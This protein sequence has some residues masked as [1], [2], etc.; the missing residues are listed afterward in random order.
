MAN[1][2]YNQGWEWV[3]APAS[4]DFW[5]LTRPGSLPLVG[6]MQDI[7]DGWPPDMTPLEKNGWVFCSHVEQ[8]QPVGP[9]FFDM[10]CGDNLYLPSPPRGTVWRA[11]GKQRYHLQPK[12]FVDETQEPFAYVYRVPTFAD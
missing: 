12:G 7:V 1:W 6:K 3:Q 4:R 2:Q 8:A 10:S 5:V 9:I 11:V